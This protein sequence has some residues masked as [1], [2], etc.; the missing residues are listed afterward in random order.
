MEKEETTCTGRT[1][2]YKFP[3]QLLSSNCQIKIKK[4]QFLL[5]IKQ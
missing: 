2:H 3:E 5:Q 4:T 1:Y